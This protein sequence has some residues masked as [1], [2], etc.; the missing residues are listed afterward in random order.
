MKNENDKLSLPIEVLELNL[1]T[2]H[3]LKRGSVFTLLDIL[4]RGEKGLIQIHQLGEK[5]ARYVINELNEFLT[6]S[7]GKTMDELQSKIY[8]NTQQP[9]VYEVS[10][11]DKPNLVKEIIPFVKS[12]VKHLKFQNDYEILKR[13]FGFELSKSYTLQEVGDYFGVSRERIRQIEFRAKEN[14]LKALTGSFSSKKWGVSQKII[15]ESNKLFSI[16]KNLDPIITETEALNMMK[17][18]YDSIDKNDLASIRFL[19]NLSGLEALPKATRETTGIAL[20]PAWISL[21][22]LEKS[23]LFKVIDIVYRLLEDEVKPVSKFDIFVKIN[24]S[25]KKKVEPV[26]FDYAVKICKEIQRV[27]DDFYEFRFES[28]PS[29]ADKAY[30]V[31]HQA[32]KPLHN[33]DILKEINY[34]QVKSGGQIEKSRNLQNQLV[35]DFRFEPV[36]RNGEWILREWE[37]INKDTFLELMQ[38][39][40]H[41]KQVSATPKEIFNY[42]R[43][44]RETAKLNSIYTYLT[45]Q[46]KLFTRVANGEY[47][48]T[49]WGLK[50]VP[51]ERPNSVEIYSQI[52]SAL[53]SI[54]AD[55]KTNKLPLWSVVKAVRQQT[56]RSAI[57]IRNRIS[58]L[59][60][61]DFEP[62]PTHPNRKY[63]RLLEDGQQRSLI[64]QSKRSPIKLIRDSVRNE[65]RDFLLEQPENSAPLSVIASHVM[66]KT[67][68]IKPTFYQYLSEM[69]NIRK[70]YS[71]AVI[72]CKLIEPNKIA[73]PLLFPQIDPIADI[74][75]QDNL[76]RAIKNLNID[77]V[78]L[79]LFQL[80]KILENE[81]RSFLTLAKAKNAFQI[82][83]KDLGR[84]VDMI[85]CIERNGIITQKHHLTLLREHRN[86]RAHG[87]I[88]NL[89]ERKK[90]MQ[91]APFLGDLYINYIVLL[92]TKT[93]NL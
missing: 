70:S 84:L 36:G 43:S 37:H 51:S 56:G 25:L 41:L 2:Y 69:E 81:L 65:V 24:G 4:N 78:D 90:L 92:N 5:Q 93:Q 31:L 27:D 77:N 45:D 72:I 8:K 52:D 54:F 6:Q 21:E 30:R 32:N 12:F 39:Y 73:E 9:F 60:N 44:K 61:F 13:R 26:Y 79:G 46:K 55:K 47:G 71:N 58:E 33:R 67:G 28:L 87:D 7:Q 29:I 82:S 66:K 16:I 76:K 59:A 23:L 85:D 89:I 18:R 10:S 83:N 88:P 53:K 3:L 74:E 11:L 34:L 57:T 80:G 15:D 38:E 48:L 40:L 14:I 35:S 50:S 86:E 91:Y 1:R 17:N 64:N 75:L 68:C 62:H 63:L 19:M 22:K 42:V 49:A 20:I